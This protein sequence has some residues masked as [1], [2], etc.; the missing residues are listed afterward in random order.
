MAGLLKEGD[1]LMSVRELSSRLSINPM[2]VSKAYSSMETEGLLERRRGIGLFV[3]G[4]KDQQKDKIKE[5]LIEEIMSKAVVTA[6]QFGLSKERLQVM[7]DE[8]FTKYQSE[9]ELTK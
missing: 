1:Q 8:S 4:I 3:V 5:A 6:V 2:T 9:K 7:L